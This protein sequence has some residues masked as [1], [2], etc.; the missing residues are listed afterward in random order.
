MSTG[1]IFVDGQPVSMLP[2]ALAASWDALVGNRRTTY[3]W[4]LLGDDLQ[5][6]GVLDGVTGGSVDLNV[7]ADVRGTGT[8]DWSGY[9]DDEPDWLHV[10]VQPW[11]R[12]EA[13]NGDVVSWP[14]VTLRPSTPVTTYVEGGTVSRSV[15]LYDRTD[16]LR[17]RHLSFDPWGTNN[18][19]PFHA[20]MRSIL[21]FA[22][23][24]GVVEETTKTPRTPMGWL[25]GTSFRQILSELCD[26]AGYFAPYADAEG[27]IRCEAYVPPAGRP[28]VWEFADGDLSIYEPGFDVEQDWYDV[29][30][31][32][33]A[34]S[35][36]TGDAPRLTAEAVNDDPSDP[37]S[38]ANRGIYS[39]VVEDV[40]A[41]DE[42]ALLAHAERVLAAR[43][44][45]GAKVTLRHGPVP[46]FPN[47]RVGF[48]RDSH[49]LVLTGV[50]QTVS[51]P[52]DP[53]ALWT[54][55]LLEVAT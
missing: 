34:L 6:L 10:H 3:E 35:Q 21:D 51:I 18:I 1:P 31:V 49:G 36:D 42:A 7:N 13:P 17:T 12:I 5:V 32:I 2:S 40:D 53:E 27:L 9:M 4:R 26:A 28:S 52:T 23:L 29:P 20:F 55:T 14:L 46:I 50:V 16:R 45:R 47:D 25:P 37:L 41:P 11:V 33:I 38:I 19:D 15:E 24:E 54:T 48:R 43:R 30:N 39:D 22:G 8:L 44:G